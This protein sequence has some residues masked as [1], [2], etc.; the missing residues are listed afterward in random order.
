MA[1]FN[2]QVRI[3]QD[4]CWKP[5]DTHTRAFLHAEFLPSSPARNRCIH[6]L[7]I[8]IFAQEGVFHREQH[9]CIHTVL[10]ETSDWLAIGGNNVLMICMDDPIALCPTLMILA[11][12]KK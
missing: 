4:Q 7:D 11:Q 8:V 5:M 6:K 2:L 9:S 3:S 1:F 12:R 10:N